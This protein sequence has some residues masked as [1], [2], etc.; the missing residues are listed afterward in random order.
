MRSSSVVKIVLLGLLALGLF[1]IMVVL[2]FGGKSIGWF[3]DTYKA[4]TLYDETFNVTSFEN[5]NVNVSSADVIVK[6]SEDATKVTVVVNAKDDYK[7][8]FHISIEKGN[9]IIAS[10]ERFSARKF[11]LGFCFTDE[12]VIIYVPENYEKGMSVKTSSGDIKF[13]VG[14]RSNLDLIASSG[15]IEV[16]RGENVHIEST[17]GKIYINKV[18]EGN[19]KSTSGDI[20]IDDAYSLVA[21]S[22]SGDITVGKVDK[23]VASATSGDINIDQADNMVSK[24]TS[25]DTRVKSVRYIESTSS[26]GLIKIEEVGVSMSLNSISGDVK[27]NEAALGVN[28]RINTTS[29]DVEI[30]EINEIRIETNTTSGDVRV[31][32]EDQ[33]SDIVLDIVTTS[34]DIKVG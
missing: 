18:S 23:I 27:I 29:G 3:V 19:I 7:D 22:T 17:S 31:K 14:V 26:S 25:G 2:L 4:V 10:E 34:G 8:S 28:S 13:E 15:D 5:I 1:V 6:K 16:L 21:E 12:T 30:G 24:T 32:K 20:K 11:C 33:D 9:L